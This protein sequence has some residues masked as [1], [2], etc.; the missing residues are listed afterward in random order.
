MGAMALQITG[1]LIVCSAV[2]SGADQ[3][4]YQISES[5]ALVR[6]IHR[7]SVHSPHKGLVTRTMF[8]SDDVIMSDEHFD[9]G[10]QPSRYIS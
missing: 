1:V 2:C 9:D 10:S 7:W 6:E 5:L 8:P 3:R 4:K